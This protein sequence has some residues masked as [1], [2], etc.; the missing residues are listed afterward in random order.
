[1]FVSETFTTVPGSLGAAGDVPEANPWPPGPA[2]PR[3]PR[4]PED[5]PPTDAGP[6][7]DGLHRSPQA[8]VS[9]RTRIGFRIPLTSIFPLETET[10]GR[11]S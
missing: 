9:R 11:Y 2:P 6:A 4:G 10:A 3:T 8:Q 1:M 5:G 7:A